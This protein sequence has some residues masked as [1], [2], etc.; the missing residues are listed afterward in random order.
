M[1]PALIV[2][3]G[4]AGA[5]KTTLAHSLAAAIGC[6][7]ICRDE[8]KEGLF[9]GLDVDYE[10]AADDALTRRASAAF[11]DVVEL[12]VGAG[13]TLVAEAAFQDHVW[14]PRLEGLLDVATVRVVRCTVDPPV[15]RRR[16]EARSHRPA[17]ADTS[18]IAD[19]DY[20]DT[21]VPVSISA[22]IIDVDTSDG[23]QPSLDRV[24]AFARGV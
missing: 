3:S 14:R 24:V 5:G 20:Y 11:F 23:Y 18:V 2:V 7:A 15:G 9:A 16:M 17:H 22:P 8:I 13:V 10:A 6:P 4:P 1:T 19:R 12:L 21:F